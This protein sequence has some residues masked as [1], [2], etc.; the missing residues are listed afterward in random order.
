[1]EFKAFPKIERLGNL[2]M[3]IT[4][5]LHGSNACIW[6][7]EYTSTNGQ[8][9]EPRLS[10]KAGCRTR[11]IF[12]GKTTDNYGFA[13]WVEKN[14]EEIIQKLGPGLH[15]GEWTGPGINSG[16]G[17][18]EKTLVLFDYHRYDPN[19]LPPNT[20]LVPILYEGPLDLS[21]VDEV[22]EDL[23]TNGSKMVPGFMRP[24]GVVVSFGGKRYKKVF[25][26][27][28]TQW[29]KGSGQKNKVRMGGPS[30]DHLLQPIRLEKLLSKDEQLIVRYPESIPEIVQLYLD[31]LVEE[32]QITGDTDEIAATKK[33][34]SRAVFSFV[35]AYVKK[36]TG[37]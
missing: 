26:A 32:G 35:R 20:A 1:M 10:A 7:F 12:P 18:K 15:Y 14:K 16:E 6:V 11:W 30:Y 19:N 8:S 27:E 29:K 25:D 13:E 23:K 9:H 2:K 3:T 5:K 28:E 33:N 24:E 34:A 37:L 17:L 21:K 22:M 4:Q 31:D 36:N